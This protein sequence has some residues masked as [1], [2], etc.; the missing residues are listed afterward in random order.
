MKKLAMTTLVVICVIIGITRGSDVYSGQR[1]TTST[2]STTTSEYSS[3]TG[4]IKLIKSK[5]IGIIERNN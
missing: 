5:A 1:T 3:V 4:S 2:V